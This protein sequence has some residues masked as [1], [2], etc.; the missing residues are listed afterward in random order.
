[1]ERQSFLGRLLNVFL[2]PTEAFNDLV[3]SVTWRDWVWPLIFLSVVLG[4][5]PRFY[6]ETKLDETLRAIQRQERSIMDNPN[7]PDD[8]KADIQGR[9]D[10]ARANIQDARSNPWKFKYQWGYILLPVY[11]FIFFSV[12]AGLLL[13]IGNFGMGGKTT[14]FQIF[15]VVALSYYI[16]GNGM[17]MQMPEGI[18]ALELIVKTPIIMAKEST[19]VIFSPGLFLDAT[20]TF[21][22]RF[23]NQFD[24]FRLWSLVVL[25]IGFAKL[26]KRSYT[27]GVW[28]VGA[29]WLVLTALGTGLAGL[30]PGAN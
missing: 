15:T 6:Q 7:I 5:A 9:F 1:M 21:I 4:V 25:G 23:I 24:I 17:L 16:G 10:K 12:W 14:F 27:T 29:L 30:I 8:R 19:Q 20:N 3:E 13:M 11:L 26:Y 22:T 2:A 28:T 18:G